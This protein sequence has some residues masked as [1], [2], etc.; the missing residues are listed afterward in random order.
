[1]HNA[2]QTIPIPQIEDLFHITSP[3]EISVGDEICS[4][5]LGDVKHWDI[6]TKPC[7]TMKNMENDEENMWLLQ[8][9][10]GNIPQ[11]ISMETIRKIM[12]K[13]WTETMILHRKQIE[14]GWL[15]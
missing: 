11:K 5:Q 7:L 9:F 3:K 10:H 6:E 12:A 8:L 4:F 1:M 15:F 14:I 2:L 13:R